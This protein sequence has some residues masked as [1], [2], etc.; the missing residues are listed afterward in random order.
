MRKVIPQSLN[1]LLERIEREN[2]VETARILR[3]DLLVAKHC[4]VL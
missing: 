1:Y 4:Q 3:M 2:I